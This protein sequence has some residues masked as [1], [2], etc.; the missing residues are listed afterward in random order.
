MA[1]ANVIRDLTQA[2]CVLLLDL[3][4]P[5][6]ELAG[7]LDH[8]FAV[9]GDPAWRNAANA[10]R[11]EIGGR[12]PIDD[13]SAIAEA[14]QLLENRPALGGL[15]RAFELVARARYPY[16]PSA[17]REPGEGPCIA[18]IVKRL[19]SKHR[20]AQRREKDA[21]EPFSAEG[22]GGTLLPLNKADADR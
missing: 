14:L 12:P 15:R 6:S 21:R 16:A 5:R 8:C 18:S 19:Q 20:A 7:I 22:Q 9:T 13:S 2:P 17:R 11:H 10:L 4:R 1:A 3:G